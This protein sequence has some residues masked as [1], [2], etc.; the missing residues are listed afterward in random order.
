LHPAV[1]QR[2]PMVVK[3]ADLIS[4]ITACENPLRT[5][6][7]VRILHQLSVGPC[8]PIRTVSRKENFKS[9]LTSPPV[10]P[11]KYTGECIFSP[12]DEFG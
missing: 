4:T 1:W 6:A 3:R 12:C 5:L 10:C 2:V 8:M 7:M 9:S 11:Y